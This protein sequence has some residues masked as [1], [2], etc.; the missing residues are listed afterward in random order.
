MRCSRSSRRWPSEPR[1]PDSRLRISAWWAANTR[2]RAPSWATLKEDNGDGDGE[3]EGPWRG[4]WGEEPKVWVGGDV[5]GTE[6]EVW[7]EDTE[8]PREVDT[9]PESRPV[10][11]VDEPEVFLGDEGWG[12]GVPV[13]EGGWLHM[14]CC[15]CIESSDMTHKEKAQ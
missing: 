9:D 7:G 15:L 12:D 13:E 1:H 10:V 4:G 6:L 14:D 8:T 3:A 11:W 5:T 2:S